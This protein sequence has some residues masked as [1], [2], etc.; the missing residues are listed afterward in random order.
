MCDVWRRTRRGNKY[1][2]VIIELTPIRDGT[3]PARLVDMV[4]GCF[5]LV[6]KA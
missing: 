3:G 5:K 6:F 4:E 1:V 2:T